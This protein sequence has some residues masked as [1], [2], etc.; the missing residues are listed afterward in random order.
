VIEIEQLTKYYGERKAVGPLSATIEDGEIIG[1]LGLNGAGKTTTLRVLACDLLPSSGTVLVDGLDVVDHPHEV[2]GKIG[3]LPDTPPLYPEMTVSEF[4]SFVARLRGVSGKDVAARVKDAIEKTELGRRRDEVIGSLSHGYKQRVGIAQAIVHGPKLLV[5]DEPIS[6]LDP[7]QIVEMRKLL[8]SLGGD[9]TVIL[10]S[11]ILGEISE[12]C[13]RILVI[14]DG[15]IADHG[16]EAELQ[17]KLAGARRVVFTLRGDADK[18]AALLR[19][20]TGVSNVETAAAS[21][22]GD[23]VFAL[24]LDGA[25][26]IREEACAALV[27]GGFGLLEVR[28]ERELESIFLSL[29]GVPTDAMQEA[30]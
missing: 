20:L 9:H 4:L 12:T 6:G 22:H 21:E 14:A 8:R 26:D 17:A 10:S 24:V 23:R 25:S 3:Y 2:R 13:D 15:R 7:K 16:T 27:G 29:A 11:H 28:A 1:L 5:L 30:S 18:A 19:G